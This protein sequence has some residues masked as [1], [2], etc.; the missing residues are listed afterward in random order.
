M[1]G[2]LQTFV[3]KRHLAEAVGERVVIVDSG[4]G[5]DLGVGPEADRRPRLLRVADALELLDGQTALEGDLVS[6]AVTLGDDLETRR[7]R[8]DAGDA[9]AVKA[10]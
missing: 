2:D 8:V 7:E 1:E 6:S 10:A 9:D 4:V 3:E 5:E